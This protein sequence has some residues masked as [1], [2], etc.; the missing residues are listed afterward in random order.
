VE[1]SPIIYRLWTGGALG[2]EYFLL[3]NRQRYGFDSALP[4][5]G[6][7]LYHVD[8]NASQND[9]WHPKVMLEQADGLWHLQSSEFGFA[10][11]GDP[12][13]PYPGT[14]GNRSAN[15]G[16]MPGTNSY[17]YGYTEVALQSISESA[18]TMTAHIFLE[19]LPVLSA[20]PASLFVSTPTGVDLGV[21]PPWT[22]VHNAGAGTLT[23][24]S[25]V[26]APWLHTDPT[27]ATGNASMDL[28]MDAAGLAFGSYTG[29]VTI[30]AGP[31]VL[32]SP[33]VVTITLTVGSLANWPASTIG[34]IT[35]AAALGDIDGDGG[36]E[37]VVGS[38]DGNVYVWYVDRGSV[39]NWPQA[40]DSTIDGSPALADIDG[41]GQLDVVVGSRDG[42]VWVW[43]GDGSVIPGWPQTTGGE[44]TYRSPAVGDLDGDGSPEI[45]VGSRDG[46]VYAWHANGT[47][48]TG[49]PQDAGGQV[50]NSP[51]M[52]DLDGDGQLEVIAGS[53]S[54]RLSV[55]HSDGTPFDGWP[56]IPASF[57][58]L[59]SPAVGDL[60]GDG[61]VE[62][63]VGCT[64]SRVY[65][66]HSN[67][68]PL[69]GWP[70]STG[71]IILGS[72][73]LGDIDGDGALEVVIGSMDNKVWAWH[74][75]GTVCPGWPQ[76]TERGVSL[77][78]PALGDLDGDGMP[79]VVIGSTDKKVYAWKGDGTL[80]PGWPMPTLGYVLSSPVLGDLDS[81]GT[82]EV[83]V[84]SQ[85][86]SVYIWSVPTA[87]SD[88]LPWPMFH[89]DPRRTGR[90]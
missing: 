77:S 69:P 20:S 8:E 7:L 21:P 39:P 76:S 60:D 5:D 54:G 14:A 71:D 23:W 33:Q 45:V 29:H 18:R 34:R 67:G 17:A 88:L 62:I 64:D 68:T 75:N 3:E 50:A 49:W 6:L 36:L 13:D 38:E 32:N 15:A 41:D 55:W 19:P 31:G 40:T 83:V 22:W 46:N 51:A 37:V 61:A 4:G 87:T 10:N 43:R 35:G 85:D 57:S 80:M 11:L 82:L 1:D 42:K 2:T 47:L 56:Q 27:Y 72:P 63:V 44:I 59:S 53:R 89:H 16:T 52:E 26:D 65:A 90:Y 79:E 58:F 74:G 48:V 24:S 81:N 86:S 9:D 25:S 70:S 66:W 30:T 84:G 12:G 78:S 28:W 73:A